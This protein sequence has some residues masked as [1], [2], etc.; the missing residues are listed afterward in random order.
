MNTAMALK[1]ELSLEKLATKN[2]ALGFDGFIDSIVRVIRQKDAD[3]AQFF[4][5]HEEF[6]HYI[7]ER[8]GAN[9]SLELVSTIQK[10]GGNMPIMAHAMSKWGCRVKC[11]G[12]FGYPQMHPLFEPMREKTELYSYCDP[13][14]T[15]A[16]EFGEGKIILGD[17]TA[18]QQ[19]NWEEIKRRIPIQTLRDAFQQSDLVAILNWSELD[20]ST[21]VWEGLLRDVLDPTIKRA[22]KTMAF[23]DLSDCSKRERHSIQH[24][25]HLLREFQ[26]HFD[27]ILGLNSNEAFQ[28]ATVISDDE[29]LNRRDIKQVGKIIL[30][31]LSVDKLI[32]HNS[33]SALAWAD[34]NFYEVP[35]VPIKN[36]KISTG[37]GDNFNAGL[38]IGLLLKL[39]MGECL[40]LAHETASVYMQSGES[41]DPYK[42]YS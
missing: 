19:I 7:L 6:A 25:L 42:Y 35:A 9:F 2:V 22:H 32:I 16:L 14:L 36:P 37:A 8:S 30:P 26:K 27:V 23:F 13:G 40:S 39:S 15:T 10:I 20:S 24:A 33:A 31:H 21:S 5:S 34:G 11:F 29:S 18:L 12:A 1:H 38:C 4:Q 3:D 17:M 28:L 41:L